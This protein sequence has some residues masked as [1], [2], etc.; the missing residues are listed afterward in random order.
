ML[1]HPGE[2]YDFNGQTPDLSRTSAACTGPAAIRFIT[3]RTCPGCGGRWPGSTPSWCTTRT[4]R[5]MAK[6][7]DIVVPSTTAYE[8]D[9]FSGSRNDPL[10]M[11]MPALTE[12]YA[13]SRNDYQTFA[14]L[15]DRLGF[16]DAVHRGPHRTGVAGAH[17]RQVGGRTRFRGPVVRPSSGRDG[18]VRLPVEEGLTLLA[19]YRADPNAHR[20]ATPER[21]HRDLLDDHRRLRVRRLRRTP[22]VVRARRVAGRRRARHAIPLH[23][24]ANQP[25]TRLHSQLDGGRHQPGIES[26]RARTDPDASGRCRGT[27]PGRRRRR[28]GVQ[29]PRGVPGRAGRSTTRL[30]PEVVQLSTG[31]WYD[32]ADPGR[33]GFD[34]RARQSERADRGRRHLVAGPRLHRRARAGAGGEVHRANSRRCGPTSRRRSWRGDRTH[35]PSRSVNSAARSRFTFDDLMRYHGPGSP[36]G[37][38]NAFKVLQRAFAPAVARTHRRTAERIVVRTA[39]RGPGARDGIE[40]VTRAVTDG[41]YTVDRTLVRADLGRLREDFVFEVAVP[42]AVDHTRTAGRVRHRGV[43]RSGPHRQSIRGAGGPAR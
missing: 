24:L 32:P 1:L 40:A 20:L 39:F 13:Q 41:R 33:P 18:Q 6:H 42:G 10:L 9:D 22:A 5:A 27:R 34:V 2:S 16:G 25:A 19:D 21:P 43:H 26:S 17:L 38:A 7:A 28:A 29:R 3:T 36:A 37:V 30:R 15:A 14:A 12:P 8:R 11:A 31:A 35:R 23:L 4:G